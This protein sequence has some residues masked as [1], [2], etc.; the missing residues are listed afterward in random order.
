[1]KKRRL[2][3]RTTILTVLLIA[4][5]YTLYANFF[6]SKETVAAGKKA[7]DFILQDLQGE[8]HRLSDYRGRGVFLNF[9][10]TYCKPC[11]RE[12]PAMQRQYEKYKEQGVDILAVN[13]DETNFAVRQFVKEY[14]LTFPVMIDKGSQVQNVYGIDQLPATY[15]VDKNGTVVDVFLGGLDESKIKEYMDE[16][17]P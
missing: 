17:K 10:G 9:W 11:E 2:V 14:G 7:P 5:C 12:M 16:I 1:M 6:T 15:L 4:L 3:I 8:K 13:V